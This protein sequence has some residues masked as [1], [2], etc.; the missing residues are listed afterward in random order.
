[1]LNFNVGRDF[2][3]FF[4]LF[5]EMNA[6]H[7]IYCVRLLLFVRNRIKAKVMSDNLQ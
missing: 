7:F 4:V 6:C 2:V 3:L 1:M 5:L